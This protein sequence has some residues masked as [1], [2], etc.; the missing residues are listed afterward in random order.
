MGQGP[1]VTA[2]PSIY[3]GA[4]R[5]LRDLTPISPWTMGIALLANWRTVDPKSDRPRG[6]LSLEA[7]ASALNI[8]QRDGPQPYGDCSQWT[9]GK[10][11]ERLRRRG[12]GP[13]SLRPYDIEPLDPLAP[14][15]AL[16]DV[17]TVPR[18]GCF[19]G[20]SPPDCTM[21]SS[22][23]AGGTTRLAVSS[24]LDTLAVCLRTMSRHCFAAFFQGSP[25]LC[26]RRNAAAKDSSGN[27]GMRW[28]RHL[29][30]HCS[31]ARIQGHTSS[32]QSPG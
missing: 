4:S 31:L 10:A 6:P 27:E 2:A 11:R 16:K 30:R 1:L 7:Y 32:L 13:D 28:G 26:G 14:G 9:Q 21:C 25:A 17:S 24:I 12:C 22:S 3:A 18:C 19:G 15:G 23:P 5:R 29:R 20:S 8:S